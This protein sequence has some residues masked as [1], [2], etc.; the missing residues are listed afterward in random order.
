MLV[1]VAAAAQYKTM[2]RTCIYGCRDL[3]VVVA[4]AAA[5][6]VVEVAAAAAAQFKTMDRKSVV[7][8]AW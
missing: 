8:E 7:A 4:A 1:E 2:D 6:V 3:V 5:G